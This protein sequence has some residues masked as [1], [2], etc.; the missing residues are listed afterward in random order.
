[1]ALSAWRFSRPSAAD[2]LHPLRSLPALSEPAKILTGPK[3]VAAT[4]GLAVNLISMK[5]LSAGCSG[6]NLKGAYFEVL[7][8]TSERHA[9]LARRHRRRGRRHVHGVD[10]GFRSSAPALGSSS[11]RVLGCC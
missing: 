11:F 1:M 4:V 10:L 8:D 5:L 2:D 3:L 9:G 6:A 7:S